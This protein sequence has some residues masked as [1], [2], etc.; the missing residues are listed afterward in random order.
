MSIRDKLKATLKTSGSMC[1]DCLSLSASIKP[2]QTVNA[3][4]RELAKT[5]ELTRQVEQCPQCKANKFVNRLLAQ[6]E[7]PPKPDPCTPKS[8]SILP[9]NQMPWY[10]EGNVQAKIVEYLMSAGWEIVKSSNTVTREQGKDIV[11]KKNGKD[12]WV[13]VKGWPEKSQ[14]PQARHWFS[15]A[16]FDLVLYKDENPNVLL[17]IGI[18]GGFK[19]YQNLIHRVCWLREN[20]PF[21]VITVS[22]QGEVGELETPSISRI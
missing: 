17:A 1:D 19:T 11:A 8:S 20:L 21:K 16:I 12:L 13:S 18:P 7:R 3:Y 9:N 4:C 6:K 22:K 15:S 14:N 5:S 10:W 2:R